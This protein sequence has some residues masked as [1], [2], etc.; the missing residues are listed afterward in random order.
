VTWTSSDATVATIDAAGLA[1]GRSPG[2]SV[3]RQLWR[4]EREH[5]A[6]SQSR[7]SLAVIRE[8]NGNGTVT[9]NPRASTVGQLL[10][11]YMAHRRDPHGDVSPD[12]TFEG[13][14]GGAAPAPAVHA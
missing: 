2:F 5:H 13:W 7:F 1:T 14:T 8:G 9:S 4:P 6:H 11:L 12:S 3:I 10:G